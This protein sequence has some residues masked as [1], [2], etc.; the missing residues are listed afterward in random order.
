MLGS[1]VDSVMPYL[2]IFDQILVRRSV[3]LSLGGTRRL[4]EALINWNESCT[5][6]RFG[7]IA[8]ECG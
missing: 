8:W 4:P 2:A 7:E 6:I 5:F 1:E 3:L